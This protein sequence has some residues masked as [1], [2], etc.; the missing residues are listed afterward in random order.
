MYRSTPH[1]PGQT[2]SHSV[3][4]NDGLTTEFSLFPSVV[5]CWNIC[6][7]WKQ[8]FLLLRS[9]LMSK[10]YFDDTVCDSGFV[11][12]FTCKLAFFGH[13]QLFFLFFDLW[14]F[15]IEYELWFSCIFH[16]I[17]VLYSYYYLINKPKFHWIYFQFFSILPT[18]NLALFKREFSIQIS[19]TFFLAI[20]IPLLKNSAFTKPVFL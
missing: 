2:C 4:I 19:R 8:L 14:L 18:M 17:A 12:D 3:Q 5:I 10:I 7:P 6:L 15:C 1:P 16:L 13:E 20:I 9:T 11:R